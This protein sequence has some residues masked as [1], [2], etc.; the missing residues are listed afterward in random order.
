MQKLKCM[1]ELDKKL[2]KEIK[3]YC[4]L[5]GLVMKEY[6]NSL[7]KKAFTADKFGETPFSGGTE[8]SSKI[9]H[10]PYVPVAESKPIKTSENSKKLVKNRYASIEISPEIAQTL[11]TKEDYTK[12]YS[13]MSLNEEGDFVYTPLTKEEEQKLIDEGKIVYMP[14]TLDDTPQTMVT[15]EST[16]IEV[17]KEVK[18]VKK[19]KKRNL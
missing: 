4:Q 10:S 9:I 17:V 3:E 13:E 11:P 12:L 2:H 7:L 8:E 1:I 18:P 15:P 19:P 6:V 16:K 5:N 14:Y